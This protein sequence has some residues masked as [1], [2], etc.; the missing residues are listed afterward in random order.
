[1]S[2]S[3]KK[4]DFWKKF[5]LLNGANKVSFTNT[6]LH[7]QYEIGDAES[8]INMNEQGYIICTFEEI[9]MFVNIIHIQ[10]TEKFIDEVIDAS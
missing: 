5:Y 3:N 8:L 2:Y 1:M 6:N 4:Y 7:E 9:D 10:I